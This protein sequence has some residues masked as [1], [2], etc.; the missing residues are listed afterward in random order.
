MDVYESEDEVC[1]LACV[2]TR[3]HKGRC[4]LRPDAL[5]PVDLESCAVYEPPDGGAANWMWLAVN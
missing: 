3:A 1:A 5:S 2:Y 4:P